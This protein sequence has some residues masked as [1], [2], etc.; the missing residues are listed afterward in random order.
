MANRTVRRTQHSVKSATFQ[1][2]ECFWA[3]S[4][5]DGALRDCIRR[6]V[7]AG[8]WPNLYRKDDKSHVPSWYSEVLLLLPNDLLLLPNDLLL[9]PIKLLLQPNLYKRKES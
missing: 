3:G 5:D 1:W 2:T 6:S 8:P 4:Y 7:L 9:L